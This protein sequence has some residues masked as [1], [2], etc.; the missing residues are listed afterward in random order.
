MKLSL[1]SLFGV[2]SR[3]A[4]AHPLGAPAGWLAPLPAARGWYVWDC[5]V[6]SLPTSSFCSLPSPPC[7]SLEILRS[8]QSE[9]SSLPLFGAQICPFDLPKPIFSLSRTLPLASRR[10]VVCGYR[11]SQTPALRAGLQSPDTPSFHL[12]RLEGEW[13]KQCQTF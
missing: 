2:L 9:L 7:L 11:K 3:P 10:L 12:S 13:D 6:R 5:A 4:G 1:L 8:K